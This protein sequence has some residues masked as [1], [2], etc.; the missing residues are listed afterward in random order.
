VFSVRYELNF[1]YYLKEIQSL[2]VTVTI[3]IYVI[4]QTGQAFKITAMRPSQQCV[5]VCV[6]S[7]NSELARSCSRTV[8]HVQACESIKLQ[9][10]NLPSR[11]GHS[12]G[13]TAGG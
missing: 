9:L 2:K 11:L 7:L 10:N 1:I 5:C 6:C 12:Q 4:P 8:G 3:V 13:G